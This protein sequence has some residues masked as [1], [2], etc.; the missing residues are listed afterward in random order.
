MKRIWQPSPATNLLAFLNRRLTLLSAYLCWYLF[1]PWADFIIR[2]FWQ[3]H[4]PR[5]CFHRLLLAVYNFIVV[6]RYSL[7]CYIVPVLSDCLP[8][9]LACPARRHLLS[10]AIA[11]LSSLSSTYS[12]ILFYT[13]LSF[14]AHPLHKC[15]CYVIKSIR[16]SLNVFGGLYNFEVKSNIT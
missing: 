3:C 13:Y 4:S 14:T 8:W 12:C 1:H 11:Y 16:W 15:S 2:P 9:Q 5:L 7:S 6:F 10:V